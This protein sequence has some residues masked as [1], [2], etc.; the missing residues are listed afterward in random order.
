MFTYIPQQ[1]YMLTS[2][3]VLTYLKQYRGNFNKELNQRTS[4]IGL[5]NL[6]LMLL[7]QEGQP[8]GVT[9]M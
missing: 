1:E 8:V 4:A 7:N 3:E 6:K 5:E 9:V 2:K